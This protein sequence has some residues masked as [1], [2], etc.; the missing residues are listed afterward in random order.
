MNYQLF[1]DNFSTKTLITLPFLIILAGC[2]STDPLE[3]Y[4]SKMAS[5]KGF[6]VEMEVSFQE[7][8]R[9]S[10][11]KI[12]REFPGNVRIETRGCR[13]LMTPK[14]GL[15]FSDTEKVYDVSPGVDGFYIPPSRIELSWGLYYLNGFEGPNF[16]QI[17]KDNPLKPDGKSNGT[18]YYKSTFQTPAG[19][20]TLRYAFDELGNLKTVKS[21]SPELTAEYKIKTL[22]TVTSFPSGTFALKVPDGYLQYAQPKEVLGLTEGDVF[23]LKSI[24]VPKSMQLP[25]LTKP[26]LFALL[27][28][29]DP[30][31]NETRAWL[32]T[33]SKTLPVVTVVEGS[34]DKELSMRAFDEIAVG[35]PMFVLV[36]PDGKVGAVWM[37]FSSKESPKIQKEIEEALK[38][39]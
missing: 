28:P 24:V 16:R 5:A 18:F 4:I 2:Q 22:T 20:G 7:S 12:S 31:G 30:F 15:D 35:T 21:Q 33:V 13:I 38:G 17:F 8:K 26:T 19:P 3:R 25:K 32:Q 14:G 1:T 27:N 29:E 9:W 34:S 10:N 37:G 6:Q 36:K 23:P 39:L 11:V